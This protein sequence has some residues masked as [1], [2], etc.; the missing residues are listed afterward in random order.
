MNQI[1][2]SFYIQLFTLLVL[3]QAFSSCRSSKDFTYL[4]DADIS[5][6]VP[7]A[8]PSL[9]YRIKIN[10]NLFVSVISRDPEM[11]KIYN[12]ATAGN[13]A[14][15]TA[16]QVWSSLQGQFVY[17]YLVDKDGF[18]NLPSMGKVRVVGMTIE[19]CQNEIQALATQFLKDVSTKVRLLNF[20]VT[21][22]GEVTNPGVHY[23]YNPE[24]TVFDAIAMAN[25]NKNTAALTNVL[26]LREAGDQV[27]T[28]KLN[29]KSTTVFNSEAYNL[30]PNDLVIVQPGKNKNLELQSPLFSLVF[31]SIAV[32]TSLLL[33]LSYNHK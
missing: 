22:I 26:V 20:K 5:K 1:R 8:L 14:A 11:N 31:S 7:R 16:N 32:L 19:E 21:V 17:G 13:A 23:N 2:S 15:A 24:C 33:L 9:A 3:A 28:Y 6:G 4:D 29:L 12:P 27:K 30:L 18:V 25:G 10:D